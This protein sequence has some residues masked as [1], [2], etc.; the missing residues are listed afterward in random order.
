MPRK[1]QKFQR[2]DPRNGWLLFAVSLVVPGGTIGCRSGTSNYRT[3]IAVN[4][5]AASRP[6]VSVN[7]NVLEAARGDIVE[8]VQLTSGEQPESAAVES[9]ESS[10]QLTATET[11]VEQVTLLKPALPLQIEGNAPQDEANQE[12]SASRPEEIPPGEPQRA[13]SDSL[14]LQDVIASVRSS[15]PAI[16]EAIAR[17]EE[18]NGQ[19]VSALGGFDYVLDGHTLNQ[20]LGFYEN[21]RHGM[22]LK[23]PLWTG[24]YLATGYRMGD[25]HF[26]PWYGER[27]T[28]EG[29]EFRLGLDVPVLQGRAIDKRRTELRNAELRRGQTNPELM[30]EILNAQAA[31]AIAYWGWV[32]AGLNVDVSERLLDLAKIRAEQIEIRITE[33]D[34]PGFV[35]L[36][37]DRLIAAREIKLI[38]AQRKFGES[39][40]KLSLFYRSPNGLPIVPGDE[41]YPNGFPEVVA[42]AVNADEQI[43]NAIERR[44]ELSVLQFEAARVRT[45]LEQAI[46]Q[47]LP[48]LNLALETSQDVGGKTSDKGDKQSTKIEAGVYGEVPLQRRFARGKIDS[49]RAKLRQLDAKAQLTADKITTEIQQIL[50][51]RQAALQQIEQAERNLDLA[52]KTLAAG[53]EGLREGEFTLPLLNIY[54]QAVADAESALILA[55]AEFFIAD[56]LL[57][58]A[59][60]RE[61]D[62]GPLPPDQAP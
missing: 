43:A 37:N 62:T 51:S 20:P 29:G 61:L 32:A 35:R 40:V 47:L 54:E 48:E 21:Y 26:E 5:K 7:A 19:I 13:A 55:E 33:G 9:A 1:D 24:G 22:G 3:P 52:E 38:D 39:A 53:T 44:P 6:G 12:G 15:F 27:E 28:D 46:N 17:Q 31:A 59:T 45:E 23:K 30:L 18:A 10:T 14:E 25:G 34:T 57:I 42:A 49:L 58:I 50:V 56:A 11:Q 36:D 8:S 41:Q 4:D 16:R 60:A 2:L